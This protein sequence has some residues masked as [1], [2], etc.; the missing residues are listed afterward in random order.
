MG[1][2]A[3]KTM[4]VLTWE[5]LYRNPDERLKMTSGGENDVYLRLQK[6][7]SPWNLMTDDVMKL[8]SPEGSTGPTSATTYRLGRSYDSVL[9]FNTQCKEVPWLKDVSL[10]SPKLPLNGF[11]GRSRPDVG[12]ILFSFSKRSRISPS[13]S[14]LW[15]TTIGAPV[16]IAKPT[17]IIQIQWRQG[18]PGGSSGWQVRFLEQAEVE[19]RKLQTAMSIYT[20][21]EDEQ[22]LYKFRAEYKVG[23][24]RKPTSDLLDIPIR[25]KPKPR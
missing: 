6:A 8:L 7:P 12:S 18:P 3:A 23:D 14:Q 25:K 17:E 10:L 24:K 15:P 19:A 16:P 20:L 9:R 13:T 1:L 21:S 2:H 22:N 11:W 5:Q 4:Y